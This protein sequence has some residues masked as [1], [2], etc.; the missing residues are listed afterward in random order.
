MHL[1]G[2]APAYMMLW[3]KVPAP[4]QDLRDLAHA[5]QMAEGWR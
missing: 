3:L 2:D 5:L 1:L 4:V